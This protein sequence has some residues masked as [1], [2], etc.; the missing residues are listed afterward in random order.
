[1]A[2]TQGENAR[3]G[4]G[5]K[6]Y[7]GWA[8]LLA[9][10]LM[11]VG[12][13]EAL[14]QAKSGP[15][16]QKVKD[17]ITPEQILERLP[18]EP[19]L[20]INV[21]PYDMPDT[22]ELV[23][24]GNRATPGL[25]NCLVGNLNE[26]VRSVCAWALAANRDPRAITTLISSLDDPSTDVQYYAV[27][28]LSKIEARTATPR[29]IE[30]LG[31]ERRSWSTRQMAVRALSQSGDPVAVEPL[32]AHFEKTYDSA[33][34]EALWEMRRHLTPAQIESLALIPLQ[35]FAMK[36]DMDWSTISFAVEH[37]GTMKIT[38]AVDLLIAVYA[39]K[40]DLRNRV[41]YNLGLIGD[42]RAVPFLKTQVDML[43]EA[44]LLNNVIFALQRLGEDVAP[45]LRTAMT[46]TRAYIRYNAAFVAGD[47]RE[48][49]LVA[50]L[51][52]ALEDPNDIVRSEAAVALGRINDRS[53]LPALTKASTADESNVRREALAS[54]LSIDYAAHTERVLTEIETT[55]SSDV[56]SRLLSALSDGDVRP[57]LS[58]L[59]MILDPSDYDERSL[60]L[61][62]L[63]AF[64]HIDNPEVSSFIVRAA[65][66][67]DHDAFR[68]LGRFADPRTAFLM[69]PWMAK[70]EGEEE[71]I[72]RTLSRLKLDAYKDLASPY[73]AAKGRKSQLYAAF[74]F[75]TFGDAPAME[76]LLSALENAPL[77]HKITAARIFTE[78]DLGAV[79]GTEDRILTLLNHED[80]YVRL[81][82]AHPLAHRGIQAGFDLYKKELDKKIPFIQYEVVRIVRRL[83]EQHRQAALK[84]WIE[85][86]DPL[87]RRD[88]E[89]I[90]AE[91]QQ[92]E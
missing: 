19:D 51:V 18:S 84:Q 31:D 3:G 68:L 8:L 41:V 28:A 38:A 17:R 53:I 83:P 12:L 36:T 1:M 23:L 82:A 16:A 47:L 34:Q 21:G 44:R 32:M 55:D 87:L 72:L 35:N 9:S 24:L 80:V 56:R 22:G 81:Y 43:G 85:N 52:K 59:F 89:A 65:A 46:D 50:D 79:G 45:L 64:D 61:R 88:L 75:A 67:G 4:A 13:G 40:E 86:A 57:L 48:A 58:R 76:I 29:L 26:N 20:L 2:T 91:P 66:G 27:S 73:L 54:M 37:A 33:T 11:M 71:Q 78:L 69:G 5:G 25:V 74:Y 30:I 63:L 10:A 6:W 42:A 70:P 7:L 49:R 14:A 90:L 77:E 60:G 92:V 39:F 62:L 15:K